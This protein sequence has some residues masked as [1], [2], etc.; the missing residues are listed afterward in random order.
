M[1]LSNRIPSLA[2]GNRGPTSTSRLLSR[3][4]AGD[5]RALSQ[6]LRQ[7]GRLLR[8]WAHGRLP[9]WARRMGDTV[10]LVQEAP[11]RTWVRLDTFDNRGR[12]ALQA[13]LRTAVQNLIANEQRR[14]GRKPTEPLSDAVQATLVGTGPSPLDSTIEASWEGRYK[15]ALSELT[16]KDRRLVVGRLEHGYSYEQLTLVLDLATP[17]QSR[18][19]AAGCRDLSRSFVALRL[20]RW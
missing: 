16:E 5:T 9:R 3:A 10:D 12:G 8:K 11:V 7:Q 1:G 14:I 13:Y 18:I 17:D 15:R 6:L 2:E 4:R 20:Q 19:R